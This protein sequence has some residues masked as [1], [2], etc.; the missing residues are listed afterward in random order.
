MVH[1]DVEQRQKGITMYFTFLY[2]TFQNHDLMWPWK[3]NWWPWDKAGTFVYTRFG[4]TFRSVSVLAPIFRKY[5]LS[6]WWICLVS[7]PSPKLHSV[8]VWMDELN[9][10]LRSFHQVTRILHS[11]TFTFLFSIFFFSFFFCP[12]A[13]GSVCCYQ[14][15]TS[16]SLCYVMSCVVQLVVLGYW[17]CFVT[18]DRWSM[19]LKF[20]NWNIRLQ[21]WGLCEYE[22]MKSRAET[23]NGLI[24]NYFGN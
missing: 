24:G 7:D 19:K 3:A 8:P 21:T 15:N 2:N 23:I 4:L 6:R 1:V 5:P 18:E 10:G 20:S 12:A 14:L 11:S 22:S 17:V 13:R 9:P 16:D